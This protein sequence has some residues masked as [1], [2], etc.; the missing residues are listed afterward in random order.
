MTD[1]AGA[2]ADTSKLTSYRGREVIRTKIAVRNAGDGLSEGMR[3]DPTELEQGSTVYVV[4]ECVVDDHTHK[5][6]KDSP[7]YLELTQ[8]LRA[9]AA[10]I[11]DG[12]TV[13][14]AIDHQKE[15]I[16]VAKQRAEGMRTLVDDEEE[17]NELAVLRR[18]HFAGVHNDEPREG[19]PV[20]EENA[21]EEPQG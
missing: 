9:G 21:A 8:V 6:I 11:I 19:C 10:T 13:K 7:D 18:Q 5:P 14:E 12:D 17:D 2:L 16:E 20:C 1:L 4:L 3:I 15:K